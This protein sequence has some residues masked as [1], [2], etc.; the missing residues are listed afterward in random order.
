[1]VMRR[2]KIVS[3]APPARASLRLPGRPAAVDFRLSR[4]NVE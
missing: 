4:G 1:M 2:G 3:E